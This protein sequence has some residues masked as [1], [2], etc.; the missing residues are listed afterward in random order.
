MILTRKICIKIVTLVKELELTTDKLPSKK[1]YSSLISNN[2]NNPTSSIHF[3]KLFKNTTLDWS[4]IYML[5][6]LATLPSFQY[7][8][9]SN[10]LLRN[11]K[12]HFW[13]AKKTLFF[14]HFGRL[15]KELLCI[16]QLIYLS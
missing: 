5:L 12:L 3:E 6:R 13:D 8:I 2:V 4:I 7:T 1:I 16:Y 14:V 11:K 15:W 10:I 9:L